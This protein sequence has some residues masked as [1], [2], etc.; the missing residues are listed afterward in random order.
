MPVEYRRALSEMARQQ[1]A[2]QTGLEVLEIGLPLKAKSEA[3][4]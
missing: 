2:D 4:K 3:R 1:Q